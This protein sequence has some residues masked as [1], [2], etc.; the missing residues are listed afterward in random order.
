MHKFKK[1]VRANGIG[2]LKI[3]KLRSLKAIEIGNAQFLKDKSISFAK[4]FI[5]MTWNYILQFWL[6]FTKLKKSEAI[7]HH[8]YYSWIKRDRSEIIFITNSV[9]FVVGY[10]FYIRIDLNINVG[11]K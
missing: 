3:L 4:F 6:N 9:C 8:I 10:Y 5:L 7:F 11:L 2:Q 1:A